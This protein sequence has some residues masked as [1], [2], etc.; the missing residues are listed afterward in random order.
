[1]KI[2]NKLPIISMVDY[3]CEGSKK[4]RKRG[5]SENMILAKKVGHLAYTGGIIL[6][7]TVYGINAYITGEFRLSKQRKVVEQ[8]HLTSEQNK[9]IYNGLENKLFG[10]R[11]LADLDNNGKISAS[12]KVNAYERRGVNPTIYFSGVDATK[13]KKAIQSYEV[14]KDS[15]QRVW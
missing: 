6:A 14:G 15:D 5:L 10:E 4:D 3:E 12:E 7:L 8:M 11:G 9:K 1:M 2:L 13:L